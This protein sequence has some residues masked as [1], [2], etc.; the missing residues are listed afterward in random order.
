MHFGGEGSAWLSVCLPSPRILIILRA[1]TRVC[2]VMYG[3]ASTSNRSIVSYQSVIAACG[4]CLHPPHLLITPYKKHDA[5]FTTTHPSKFIIQGHHPTFPDV[6]TLHRGGE[7]ALWRFAAFYQITR[8][9]RLS[10]SPSPSPATYYR[11]APTMTAHA[12]AP[13]S[14]PQPQTT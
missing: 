7:G 13:T 4:C 9:P 2:R 3:R 12:S 1:Y 14:Q 10:P 6:S 11:R 5:I 8:P